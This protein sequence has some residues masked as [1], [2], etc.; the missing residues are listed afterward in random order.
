M[1]GRRA[2]VRLIAAAVLCTACLG[3]QAVIADGDLFSEAV[4]KIS[5][6]F[7][8]D[9]NEVEKFSA[10]KGNAES[11]QDAQARRFKHGVDS[12]A[13]GIV[14]I[15]QQGFEQAKGYLTGSTSKQLITWAQAKFPFRV[16]QLFTALRNLV[17]A[18]NDSAVN[19]G[20]TVSD[21]AATISQSASAALD[22]K[23][24]ESFEK[25]QHKAQEGAELLKKAAQEAGRNLQDAAGDVRAEL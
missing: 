16:V 1:G 5:A 15:A 25:L 18:A 9:P 7:K 10:A 2:R 14:D 11:L 21:T 8:Q 24:G 6:F 20:Q 3:S 22:S 17:T 23:S 4:S 12:W 19:V 13:G